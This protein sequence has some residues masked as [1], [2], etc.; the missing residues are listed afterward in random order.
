ML[1]RV[2]FEASTANFQGEEDLLDRIRWYVEHVNNENAYLFFNADN[3]VVAKVE[4]D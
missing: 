2:T 3:I 4:E 1:V